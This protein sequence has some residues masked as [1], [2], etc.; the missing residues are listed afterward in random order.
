MS[1]NEIASMLFRI[2]R[3]P[4][5]VRCRACKVWRQKTA[6]GGRLRRAEPA[7]DRAAGRAGA[8]D[9]RLGLDP[10]AKIHAACDAG[11]AARRLSQ[12]VADYL[13]VRGYFPSRTFWRRA[14]CC[15]VRAS[16]G[17]GPMWSRIPR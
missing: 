12:D 16:T 8:A 14:S 4:F 15:F 11:A 10:E 9:Q 1:A 2:N 13:S 5:E 3:K 7:A 17:G 6:R